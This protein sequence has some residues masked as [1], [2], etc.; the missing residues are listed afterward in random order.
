M[1]VKLGINGFGRIGKM[2]LTTIARQGRTDAQVVAINDPFMDPEYMA[3]MLKYDTVHGRFKGTVEAKDGNLVVNGHT[4][5]V[6]TEKEPAKIPW[7][8][9]GV[10]VVCESTGVFTEIATAG[11][12]LQGGAK[13]VVISAPSKDAPMFVMGVNQ[14]AYNGETIVSNASVWS[15]PLL[16]ATSRGC[17][18]L[19]MSRIASRGVPSPAST[20]RWRSRPSR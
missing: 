3:Y 6:Y 2:V 16:M 14:A 1:S 5:K 12:H 19:P 4:I 10:D 18:G 7:G 20:S 9:N 8:A 15:R 11:L 13:K 17:S